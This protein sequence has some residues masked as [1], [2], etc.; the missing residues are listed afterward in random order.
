MDAF[1][2]VFMPWEG[3]LGFLSGYWH[4]AMTLKDRSKRVSQFV[5]SAV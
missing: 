3:R 4:L 2:A 5:Y 1:G